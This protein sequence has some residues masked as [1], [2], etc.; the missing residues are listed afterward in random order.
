MAEQQENQP[1]EN[2]YSTKLRSLR[3]R[4]EANLI[5][6]YA[7]FTK[8]PT[9]FSLEDLVRAKT[10]RDLYDQ[11]VTA[12]QTGEQTPAQGK[13]SPTEEKPQE[14]TPVKKKPVKKKTPKTNVV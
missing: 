4:V 11:L 9:E 6:A 3:L 12:P 8:D 5:D 14:K 1:V 7:A 10:S 13:T 2:A